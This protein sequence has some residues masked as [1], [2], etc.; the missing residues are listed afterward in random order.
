MAEPPRFTSQGRTEPRQYFTAR[1][2][3]KPSPPPSRPRSRSLPV[4]GYVGALA[5]NAAAQAAVDVDTAQDAMVVDDAGAQP[6]NQRLPLD[7]LTLVLEAWMAEESSNPC[8]GWR[9]VPFYALQVCGAW[10]EAAE[11]THA[12]WQR[13]E[14]FFWRMLRRTAWLEYIACFAKY[15]GEGGFDVSLVNGSAA[16]PPLDP[17]WSLFCHHILPMARNIDLEIYSKDANCDILAGHSFPLLQTLTV[18]FTAVEIDCPEIKLFMT[19]PNLHRLELAKTYIVYY[20]FQNRETNPLWSLTSLSIQRG[21]YTSAN[22][23]G[24][25]ATCLALREFSL[26]INELYHCDCVPVVWAS[27]ETLRVSVDCIHDGELILPYLRLPNLTTLEI[28]DNKHNW[29]FWR[30]FVETACPKVVRLGVYRNNMDD[31]K[32]FVDG[33]GG[34]WQIR[35]LELRNGSLNE[36]IVTRLVK[37]DA[38][39]PMPFPNLQRIHFEDAVP[40]RGF[41]FW[42][43]QR[44]LQHRYVFRSKCW[45]TGPFIFTCALKRRIDEEEENERRA[46]AERSIINYNKEEWARFRPQVPLEPMCYTFRVDALAKVADRPVS[47]WRISMP[48]RR[49]GRKG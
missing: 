44:A 28:R 14:F 43:I 46:G 19:A 29:D 16:V 8:S 21:Q 2:D 27:L 18:R 36:D 11:V 37:P 26:G 47:V 40:L 49:I 33:M 4:S 22:L 31:A 9:R 24:M 48:L 23:C 13:P 6:N 41:A 35:E 38:G 32:Q 3:D 42:L 30:Q 25:A 7:V 1:D 45:M 10:R 5:R 12:L 15:G 20:D 17:V 39:Q 34:L